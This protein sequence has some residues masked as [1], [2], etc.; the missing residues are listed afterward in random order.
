LDANER[1]TAKEL[2]EKTGDDGVLLLAQLDDSADLELLTDVTDGS[3]PIQ[4]L[5]SNFDSDVTYSDYPRSSSQ[6]DIDRAEGSVDLNNGDSMD[7][8]LYYP[9][10]R[11]DLLDES[12]VNPDR[13]AS[14][15][16]QTRGDIFEDEVVPHL[17]ERD[18]CHVL[19]S[20][21]DCP[22]G[23]NG[24]DIMAWDSSA[25][26]G[27]GQL[28][29]VEAKWRENGGSASTSELDSAREI[30]EGTDARQMTDA[31]IRD[32]WN[33]DDY[34]LDTT[35]VESDI[36]SRYG[37]ADSVDEAVD[38]ALLSGPEDGYNREGFYGTNDRSG[39]TVSSQASEGPTSGQQY[40]TDF[41]EE[42]RY[43]KFGD[44]SE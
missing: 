8:E 12:G 26:G 4:T 43:L 6:V 34:T 44:G 33:N 21:A 32:S 40:M 14:V 18:G 3:I 24:I 22:G 42:T 31:W 37:D 25:N 23:Q 7:T 36:L 17:L 35:G 38:R 16:G 11:R 39:T 2:V 5:N 15:S 29:V 41:F 10:S 9:D 20:G 27:D 30:S 13:W 19:C 28:V 1:A